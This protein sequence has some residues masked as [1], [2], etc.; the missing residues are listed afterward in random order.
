MQNQR[1]SR[2]RSNWARGGR[3]AVGY[4]AGGGSRNWK[5]ES[6]RCAAVGAG[7]GAKAAARLVR[8][9][10]AQV[11]GW[12]RAASATVRPKLC[13]SRVTIR[14]ARLGACGRRLGAEAET[15]SAQSAVVTASTAR[16]C[17]DLRIKAFDCLSAYRPVKQYVGKLGSTENQS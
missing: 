15:W 1:Q 12:T 10:T 9:V 11:P 6:G 14:L 7:A 4:R 13:V 2:G 17:R 5:G 16:T 3:E 8:W